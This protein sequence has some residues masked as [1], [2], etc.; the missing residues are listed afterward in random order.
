M[1]AAPLLRTP[2]IVVYR[3]FNV[4]G[5]LLY[6]GQTGD[7]SV[8]LR[9]HKHDKPWWDEVAEMRTTPYLSKG[10][11]VEAERVAIREERPRYNVQLAVG[12][13]KV[14]VNFRV[15]EPVKEAALERAEREGINLS[16]AMRDLLTAWSKGEQ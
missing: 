15:P 5:D 3:L 6:I 10:A 14:V 2:E 4:E 16:D 8:R 12:S 11:A 1:S 7:I 9:N 13:R